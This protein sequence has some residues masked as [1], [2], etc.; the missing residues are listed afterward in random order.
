MK[1]IIYS[2]GEPSGIGPD[3]IIQIAFSKSW[4]NF[5]IPILSVGDP[6]LFLKRS[7][8]L[9][10]KLKVI[11]ITSVDSLNKNKKGSSSGY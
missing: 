10:K 6:A 4:E 11:D 7:K 2:P 1:K 5:K 9:R 3:L 8:L